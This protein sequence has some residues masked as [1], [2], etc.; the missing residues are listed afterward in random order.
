MKTFPY[1]HLTQLLVN[2]LRSLHEVVDV[3]AGRQFASRLLEAGQISE[4]AIDPRG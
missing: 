2:N 1:L 3:V 4:H